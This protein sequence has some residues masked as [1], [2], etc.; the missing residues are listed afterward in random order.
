MHME[1]VPMRLE[2][3]RHRYLGFV[4]GLW[5]TAFVLGAPRVAAEGAFDMVAAGLLAVVAGFAIACVVAASGQGWTSRLEVLCL[6]SG[7]PL[8]LSARICFG[9]ILPGEWESML[10][11]VAQLLILALLLVVLPFLLVARSLRPADPQGV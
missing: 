1:E 4:G 2:L 11:P 7:L 3:V 8:W 5:F 10:L 9:L 6:A